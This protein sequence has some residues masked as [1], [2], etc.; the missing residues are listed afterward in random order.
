MVGEY[1][2][3]NM[4]KYVIKVIKEYGIT[5]NLGYFVI[6]NAPNNDTMMTTLSLALRR[7]FRL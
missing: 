7:D 3:E 1:I 6:D 4:L 2:E 5:H